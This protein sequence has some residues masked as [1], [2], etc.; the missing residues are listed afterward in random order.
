MN[1]PRRDGEKR[2][3]VE[4]AVALLAAA[5]DLSSKTAARLS[6]QIY[7]LYREHEIQK[8]LDG[9]ERIFEEGFRRDTRRLAAR[10]AKS[11]SLD[12]REYAAHIVRHDTLVRRKVGKA[13]AIER[14]SRAEWEGLTP[15]EKRR[16]RQFLGEN[17]LS[18]RSTRKP[19]PEFMF[20][21]RVLAAVESAIGRKLTFSSH[22]FGVPRAKTAGDR[23]YGPGF[24][25]MQAV[26]EMSDYTLT[27]EALANLIRRIRRQGK[28]RKTRAKALIPK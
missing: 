24:D 28:L 26:A 11:P 25:V 1:R 12:D 3:R 22:P 6:R 20:M 19:A 2:R 9:H 8:S 16:A 15:R 17:V 4:A 7:K 5:H 21:G 27:N 14:G 23:H 18:G 10:A 13:E